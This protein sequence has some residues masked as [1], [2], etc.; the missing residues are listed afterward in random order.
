MSIPRLSGSKFK[1]SENG[2]TK[3]KEEYIDE[4]ERFYELFVDYRNFTCKELMDKDMKILN[5]DW[6][7]RTLKK[8]LERY[9]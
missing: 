1:Y 3:S 9:K 5:R 6:E 7:I 2:T 4:L 8:K